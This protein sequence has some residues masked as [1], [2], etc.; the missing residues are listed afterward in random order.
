MRTILPLMLGCGILWWMYREFD[1][2]RVEQTLREEMSWGWMLFSL[3]FGLSAEV[4]RGVRWMQ[5]LEPLGEHPRRSTCI[6][7]VFISYMASLIIPRIGEV[8]RCEILRRYDN[9][10][11]T[12]SLGTVVTERMVD[13]LLILVLTAVIL[14][15]QLPVFLRFFDNTGFRFADILK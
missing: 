9:V 2:S 15:L 7:A 4:L 6:H 14:F 3:V 11:F 1:F 12:K 10:S 8:T 5:T 13:S